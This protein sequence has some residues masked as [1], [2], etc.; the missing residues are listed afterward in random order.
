MAKL[1]GVLGP[2]VKMPRERVL[3]PTMSKSGTTPNLAHSLK[4]SFHL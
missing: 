3:N 2:M 4:G 1:K